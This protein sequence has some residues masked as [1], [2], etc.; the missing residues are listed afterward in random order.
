MFVKVR[1][2]Y[3]RGKIWHVAIVGRKKSVIIPSKRKDNA[4]IE[5]MTGIKKQQKTKR[6]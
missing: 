4:L 2:E 5:T 3:G 1:N 6:A